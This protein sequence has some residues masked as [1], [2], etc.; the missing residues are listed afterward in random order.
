MIW[1]HIWWYGTSHRV[2]VVFASKGETNMFVILMKQ[3]HG[4][5]THETPT[6]Q[7]VYLIIFYLIWVLESSYY[8]GG[9]KNKVGVCQSSSLYIQKI[10][11]WKPKISLKFYGWPWLGLRNLECSCWKAAKLLKLQLSFSAELN[12]SW[13]EL[14]QLQLCWTSAELSFLNSSWTSTSTG[15]QAGSTGVQRGLTGV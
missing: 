13:V 10:F 5:I 2:W 9:S 6:T 14:L 8:K 3:H 12:L 1:T 7:G 11:F 4:E 15:V